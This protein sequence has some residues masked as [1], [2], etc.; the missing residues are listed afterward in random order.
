MHDNERYGARKG[1]SQPLQVW[2]SVSVRMQLE[3]KYG[4]YDYADEG[5][6]EVAKDEIARLGQRNV[7]SAVTEYSRS[8][9]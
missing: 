4:R 3:A 9:L 7:N 1:C 5:A 2:S 6:E 8:T